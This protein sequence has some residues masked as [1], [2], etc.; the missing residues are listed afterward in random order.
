MLPTKIINIP[1]SAHDGPV[2]M[3]D[4]T[5]MLFKLHWER[6]QCKDYYLRFHLPDSNIE[7]NESWGA[8]SAD[9]RIKYKHWLESRLEILS[10]EPGT[11]DYHGVL[12]WWS[13]RESYENRI[14]IPNPEPVK[15][16]IVIFPLIDARY[17]QERNWPIRVFQEILN[18]YRSYEGYE[19]VICSANTFRNINTEGYTIST[20]FMDNLNH[21][22]ESNIYVGGDTGFTHLAAALDK[23]ERLLKYYYAEGH[24]GGWPSDYTRPY[25]TKGQLLFFKRFDTDTWNY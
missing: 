21:L 2:R 12:H 4:L 22:L 13:H 18:E 25:A 1:K 20:D 10:T 14:S 7:L 8:V 17:N 3:G 23:P 24:H 5:F 16:K 11:E 6:E 15:N 9:F 19:R